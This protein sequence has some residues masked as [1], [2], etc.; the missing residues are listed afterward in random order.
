MRD[1]GKNKYDPN[2]EKSKLT[3]SIK[4]DTIIDIFSLLFPCIM[5]LNLKSRKN[6]KIL[7]EK[8]LNDSRWCLKSHFLII[9][10]RDNS[11]KFTV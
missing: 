11:D 4:Y 8:N 2:S 6:I 3:N 10:I 1:K 7:D 5:S 9:I